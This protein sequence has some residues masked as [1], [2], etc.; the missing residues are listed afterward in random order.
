CAGEV[1]WEVGGG[2]CP[3]RRPLNRPPLAVVAGSVAGAVPRPLGR[4]PVD[5]TVEVPTDGRKGVEPAEL[6]T[7][8]RRLQ[9]PNA[10]ES[11]FAGLQLLDRRPIRP[12]E[13]VGEEV[14][15]GRGVLA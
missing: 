4:I 2:Q 7:V 10:D 11:A 13:A 3:C 9:R 1:V 15:A 6:V 8:D 14:E 12:S 5:E